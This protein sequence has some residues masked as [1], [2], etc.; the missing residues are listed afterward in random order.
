M[1]MQ[2]VA[3]VEQPEHPVLVQGRAGISAVAVKRFVGVEGHGL[4][5]PVE[6]V[7]TGDVSPMLDPAGG[8]K[9]AVLVEHMVGVAHLAQ[10]VGV[11]E[12][13]HWRLDVQPLAVRVG[14]CL[15]RPKPLHQGD[16]VL[17]IAVQCIHT[18]VSS[19]SQIGRAALL[20]IKETLPGRI[21]KIIT[22]SLIG[23]SIAAFGA[24]IH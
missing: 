22:V 9:G 4:A 11:V 8:V 16:Q 15:G 19:G 2:S 10:A 7:G 17:Q 14:G 18:A 1:V 12:P 23:L 3:G 20:Q 6:Q 24:K 5:L 13:A 21:L